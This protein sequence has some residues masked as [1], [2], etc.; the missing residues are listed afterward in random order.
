[1]R[2]DEEHCACSH[3]QTRL[4]RRDVKYRGAVECRSFSQK[5]TAVAM[6]PNPT[7]AQKLANPTRAYSPGDKLV[8][9]QR[10]AC[11][12]YKV[13]RTGRPMQA[14]TFEES[15]P[16][17]PLAV[18]R[19]FESSEPLTRRGA[20]GPSL[21]DPSGFRVLRTPA[22]DDW[23]ILSHCR[24]RPAA[25]IGSAS[26][27]ALKRTRRPRGQLT[28]GQDVQLVCGVLSVE[29]RAAVSFGVP[30]ERHLL[31]SDDGIHPTMTDVIA[32]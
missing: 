30:G 16:G 12:Y 3:G 21:Q 18:S 8:M 17:A 32:R 19:H 4:R 22:A 6:M 13:N 9:S 14:I 28:K 23:T 7:R 10:F 15:Y 25:A 29:M 11:C 5:Y 27:I 20:L 24:A 26:R 31:Q 2:K 1:M